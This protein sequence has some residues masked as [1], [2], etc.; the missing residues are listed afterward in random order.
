MH[1]FGIIIK[2]NKFGQVNEVSHRYNGNV[3]RR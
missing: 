2:E 1:Q 3:V